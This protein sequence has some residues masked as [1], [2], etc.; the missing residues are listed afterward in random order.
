MNQAIYLRFNDK[1]LTE[2]ISQ[3]VKNKTPPYPSVKEAPARCNFFENSQTKG[4]QKNK[5]QSVIN[6]VGMANATATY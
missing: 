2:L 4:N 6:R 1:K 5:I 3:P